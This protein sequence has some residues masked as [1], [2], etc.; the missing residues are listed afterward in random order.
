MQSSALERLASCSTA[1]WAGGGQA[2]HRS[3][4]ALRLAP[5]SASGRL[6]SRTCC[7]PHSPRAARCRGPDLNSPTDAPLPG[8]SADDQ[9]L[10]AGHC[11]RQRRVDSSRSPGQRGHASIDRAGPVFILGRQ[12]A[13]PVGGSSRCGSSSEHKAAGRRLALAGGWAQCQEHSWATRRPSG[14]RAVALGPRSSTRH[15][16]VFVAHGRPLLRFPPQAPRQHAAVPP[17][18]A[19]RRAAARRADRAAGTAS[20]AAA[21]RGARERQV[22]LRRRQQRRRR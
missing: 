18:A 7:A 3:V 1:C 6:G 16:L 10:L 15:C 13:R 9:A 22:R 11:R 2:R 21:A 19:R 4:C 8:S 17:A 20:A 14:A 12:Q 5:A